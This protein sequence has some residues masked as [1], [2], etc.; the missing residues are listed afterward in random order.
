[1]YVY[2]YITNNN[3]I[4]LGPQCNKAPSNFYACDMY[5]G[6][7][8][9]GVGISSVIRAYEPLKSDEALRSVQRLPVG[10]PIWS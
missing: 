5:G 2:L 7:H 4:C 10:A 1:M 9:C 6:R 8:C 3:I